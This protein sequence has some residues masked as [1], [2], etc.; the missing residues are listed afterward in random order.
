MNATFQDLQDAN[1]PRNGQVFSDRVTVVTL[2]QELRGI[3]PPFVC[4]FTGANGFNLTIG[5]AHD[6]GCVQH[7]SNDGLPP[8]LMAVSN[9]G[10]SGL[11]DIEFL[12]GGTPTPIDGRYRIGFEELCETVAQFVDTGERGARVAWEELA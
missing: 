11:D 6:F 8:Y 9:V 4:Q 5:V 2:L 10:G 12:C 3:E 1:N 7:C